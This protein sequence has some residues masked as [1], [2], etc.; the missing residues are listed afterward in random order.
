MSIISCIGNGK[1]DAMSRQYRDRL[2]T[3]S[4]QYQDPY[5]YS[6]KAWRI[7]VPGLGA[8]NIPGHP[9]TGTTAVI[10]ADLAPDRPFRLPQ[11]S[12]T[13]V[14]LEKVSL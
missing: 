7:A 11:H 2:L 13:V 3:M 1:Q 5:S 12:I 8:T 14:R 4:I 9:E 6:V 10:S